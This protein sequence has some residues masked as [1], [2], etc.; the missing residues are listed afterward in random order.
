MLANLAR[1]G[2]KDVT[3][4]F[5]CDKLVDAARRVTSLTTRRARAPPTLF[6]TLTLTLTVTLTLTLIR[7]PVHHRQVVYGPRAME[8]VFC[9]GGIDGGA[10]DGD[11]LDIASGSVRGEQSDNHVQFDLAKFSGIGS[12]PIRITALAS[13]D[14]FQSR[15]VQLFGE[16][17][18]FS[19]EVGKKLK[20]RMMVD[21]E[22]GFKEEYTSSV[23]LARLFVEVFG[24]VPP[25]MG[26]AMTSAKELERADHH[27]KTLLAEVY[28]IFKNAGNVA[29]PDR[30]RRRDQDHPHTME[31]DDFYE[32][33]MRPYYSSFS[34][35]ATQAAFKVINLSHHGHIE[36]EE[37]RFW[38]LWGLHEYHDEISSVDQLLACVF[39]RAILPIQIHFLAEAQANLIITVVPKLVRWSNRARASTRASVASPHSSRASNVSW[40]SDAIMEE[41]EDDV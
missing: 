22:S 2:N 29:E 10:T 13:P 31:R 39:T 30:T 17:E 23:G 33:F 6:L 4:R 14:Q 36:W 35:R 37:W 24:H 38:L 34:S 8:A 41:E 11:D 19:L 1:L 18:A 28:E 40:K 3:R 20:A 27:T 25:C 32:V 16:D 12:R 21:L 7:H 9:F 15:L 26:V 5:A